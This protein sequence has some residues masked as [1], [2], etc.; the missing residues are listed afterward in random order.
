VQY[1]PRRATVGD[2][3]R[4]YRAAS[5]GT[6]GA[7]DHHL[8][9]RLLAAVEMLLYWNPY[10]VNSANYAGPINAAEVFSGS[11]DDVIDNVTSVGGYAELVH[12]RHQRCTRQAC[13]SL[14]T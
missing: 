13:W 9:V 6:F 10:D 12:I 2:G 4:C 11:Y 3:N 8:H 1:S 7:R 5:L 14:I